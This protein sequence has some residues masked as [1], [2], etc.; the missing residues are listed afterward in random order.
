M[1][2]ATVESKYPNAMH[3]NSMIK[4]V[5]PNSSGVVGTVVTFI[6]TE[7][8]QYY[9]IRYRTHHYSEAISECVT[10]VAVPMR[11]YSILT[12]RFHEHATMWQYRS[13]CMI[14]LNS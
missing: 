3:E 14:N 6:I 10:H 13:I 7:N 4:D 11:C 2:P 5:N 8:D 9:A 1:I 12:T